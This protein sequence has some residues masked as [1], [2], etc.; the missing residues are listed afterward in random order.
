MAAVRMP[1]Q[2]SRT[3]SACGESTS[4]ARYIPNR[5]WCVSNLPFGFHTSALASRYLEAVPFEELHQKLCHL[6]GIGAGNGYPVHAERPQRLDLGSAD[7]RG[8]NVH[9]IIG[10]DETQTSPPA[11]HSATQR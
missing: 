4:R 7:G 3:H 10:G 8:R 9:G 6:G 11:A 2:A 1:L 5:G